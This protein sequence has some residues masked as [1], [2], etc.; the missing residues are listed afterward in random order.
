MATFHGEIDDRVSSILG[1]L[2]AVSQSALENEPGAR[3][4]M[5]SL[6]LKLTAA[7]ET[8]SEMIQR[9]GWAEVEGIPNRLLATIDF[10][11]LLALP[12]LG[13]P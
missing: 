12:A 7:L 5:L 11:S 2:Q 13:L 3:E 1:K 9:V 4:T 6:S 10:R 8:S